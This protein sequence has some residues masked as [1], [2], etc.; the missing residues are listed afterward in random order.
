MYTPTHLH[1]THLHGTHLHAARYAPGGLEDPQQ[2]GTAQNADPERRH[3]VHVD[4]HHL[5]DAAHHHEAVEAVEQGHKITLE[6]Q[7]VHLQ[8]HLHC[9]E[10]HK[11]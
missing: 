10:D 9:K 11:K 1:G 7:A 3:H 5:Q 6:S 8:E 4:H 2:S